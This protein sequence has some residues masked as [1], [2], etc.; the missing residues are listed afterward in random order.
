MFIK[1]M[2]NNESEYKSIF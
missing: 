2:A 1:S